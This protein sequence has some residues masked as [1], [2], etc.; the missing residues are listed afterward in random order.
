MISPYG[1]TQF[2]TLKEGPVAFEETFYNYLAWSPMCKPERQPYKPVQERNALRQIMT[3][4]ASPSNNC[5]QM[6]RA[7]H[8]TFSAREQLY[9]LCKELPNRQ[10]L[11]S[12]FQQIGPYRAPDEAAVR[13][14][15][16]RRL[17]PPD[18]FE[19]PPTY[20]GKDFSL[21]A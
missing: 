20:Y 16:Y 8:P 21:M 12:Q 11:M 1:E 13:P 10:P 6:T 18:N 3:D 14:T 2:M 15:D 9:V 4:Q 7:K 19:G 17:L 5:N